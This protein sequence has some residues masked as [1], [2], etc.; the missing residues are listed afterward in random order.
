M[1]ERF[2]SLYFCFYTTY[3]QLVSSLSVV[4]VDTVTPK[5]RK[6]SWKWPSSG[7]TPHDPQYVL[8]T[9][10]TFRQ[11]MQVTPRDIKLYHDTPRY[12][13]LRQGTPRLVT[14]CHDT[15]HLRCNPRVKTESPS[16]AFFLFP[17]SILRRWP[18]LGGS[19]WA[20][21]SLTARGNVRWRRVNNGRIVRG[22]SAPPFF[23]SCELTGHSR[24]I[25]FFLRYVDSNKKSEEPDAAFLTLLL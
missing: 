2:F 12:S 17:L 10:G 25:V 18:D 1:S 16:Q 23:F 4:P 22:D 24:R 3:R 5:A 11:G 20:A 8:F 15:P 19:L 13:R 7:N 9:P 14:S 6:Y 21:F